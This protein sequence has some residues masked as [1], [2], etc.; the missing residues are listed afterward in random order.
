MSLAPLP[1]PSV[2]PTPTDTPRPTLS[3]RATPRSDRYDV[4]R[5]CGDAPRCWVYTVRSGDNLASIA[6]WFGIPLDTVHA[7]NP[8]TLTTGLR[9]GQEL[10]LPPPT[11]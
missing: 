11:R 2:T 9:A 5:P 10:R 1:S 8:W 4:L 6:H 3:P 7:M